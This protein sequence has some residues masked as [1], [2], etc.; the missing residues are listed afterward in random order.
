MKGEDMLWGMLIHVGGNITIKPNDRL[1]A[2]MDTFHRITDRMAADGL[3]TVL[4]DVH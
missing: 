1:V 4:I 2:D 3:N